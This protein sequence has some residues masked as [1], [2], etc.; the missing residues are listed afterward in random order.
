[1][2]PPAPKLVYIDDKYDLVEGLKSRLEKHAEV[3]DIT[4][5]LDKMEQ[6]KS[7]TEKADIVV[8]D[9]DLNNT[10][11]A[12]HGLGFVDGGALIEG[13]ASWRR[14]SDFIHVIFSGQLQ[15]IEALEEVLP[16]DFASHPH[17]LA[18]RLGVDWVGQKSL[19]DNFYK[20]LEGLSDAVARINAIGSD[21]T[22]TSQQRL[23]RLL[24]ASN[25][26]AI[27]SDLAEEL[28]AFGPPPIETSGARRFDVIRWLLL[29]VL[30]YPT[31]LI[32]AEEVARRV[33]VEPNWFVNT[34]SDL[35]NSLGDAEYRGILRDV[36]QGK[37]WWTRHVESTLWTLSEGQTV[38]GDAWQ[39]KLETL[40]VPKNRVLKLSDPAIARSYFGASTGI[41]L[42]VSEAVRINPPHWPSAAGQAYARKSDVEQDSLLQQIADPN[43]LN[44]ASVA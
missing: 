30:P 37:R 11:V 2:A 42:D 16:G 8:S 13:V 15:Q 34:S 25:D 18:R 39:R 23:C 27:G 29:E 19:P 4:S 41:V 24:G 3:I 28:P 7:A 43:D 1:M 33:G 20:A 36:W 10:L 44:S 17:I 31:F 14:S 26:K 6:I 22:Y 21:N 12:D 38:Y 5:S 9:W 35:Q 40:G 32:D